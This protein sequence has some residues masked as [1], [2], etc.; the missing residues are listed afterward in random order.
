MAIQKNV[1]LTSNFGDAQT[2]P[3]AY[4]KVARISGTKTTISAVIEIRKDAGGHLLH[5]ES[6]I[7]EPSMSKGNFIAQAYEHIKTLPDYSGAT[8]I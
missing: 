8:D 6:W 5:S 7:F 4:I 1:T 3:N 2:F